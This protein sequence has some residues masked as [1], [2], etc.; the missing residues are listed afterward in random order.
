MFTHIS[1][2]LDTKGFRELMGEAPC[3][4]DLICYKSLSPGGRKQ[5]AQKHF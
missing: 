2:S 4:N 1:K 3:T 5:S